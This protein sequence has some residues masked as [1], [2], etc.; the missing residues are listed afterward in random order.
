MRDTVASTM[1]LK[2]L[3][4]DIYV[5]ILKQLPAVSAHP[6]DGPRTLVACL[7]SN[8]ILR[9]AASVSAL[10]EPHYHVRYRICLPANELARRKALGDDWKSLYMERVRLDQQAI[11]ILDGIVME[12]DGRLERARDVTSK[13]SYDVWNVLEVEAQ[14]PI[15]DPF[16]GIQD[17]D[18]SKVIHH[19]IPRRFWARS[20]LGAIARNHAVH[21]WKGIKDDGDGDADT[22]EIAIACLSSYFTHPPMEVSDGHTACSPKIDTTFVKI[23]SL[24]DILSNLCQSYLAVRD[25]PTIP[26]EFNHS[27]G[28]LCR[29][30]SSI[31]EFLWDYGF[32]AAECE[33]H[34]HLDVVRCSRNNRLPI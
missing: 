5:H 22:L 29:L 1:T 2:E 9:S 28:S 19:A 6:N 27:E 18:Q 30:S 34:T 17:N 16:R 23:S 11:A 4:F 20:L 32:R 3:P 26:S 12:R 14:C 31:C 25:I 15:L 33:S 7:Q 10:W 21:T 8:S 13:L 24:L